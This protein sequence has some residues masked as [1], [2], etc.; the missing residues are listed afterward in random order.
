MDTGG[1]FPGGKAKGG[2]KLTTDLH[3]VPR[4][5]MA[6]LYLHSLIRLHGIIKRRGTFTFTLLFRSLRQAF[7]SNMDL[8][9]V[10]KRSNFTVTVAAGEIA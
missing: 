9:S 10:H 3:L 7:F 1:S 4:S 5:K 6:E 2:V 8:G